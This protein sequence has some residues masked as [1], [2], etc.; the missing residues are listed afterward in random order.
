[1]TTRR[2]SRTRPSTGT[3]DASPVWDAETIHALGVSTDLTTAAQI[4]NLSIATAYRLVKRNAFPV[5]VIRAGAHY[6]V[7]VAPILTALGLTPTA[8]RRADGPPP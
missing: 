8:P 7:P 4:F 5:P 3:D 1:M 6:R 2:T